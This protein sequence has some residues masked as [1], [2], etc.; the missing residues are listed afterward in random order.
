MAD[1]Q[2]QTPAAQ[3][4]AGQAQVGERRLTASEV[5]EDLAEDMKQADRLPFELIPVQLEKATDVPRPRV[6][7]TLIRLVDEARQDARAQLDF[8]RLR[9]G[10]RRQRG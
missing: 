3:T 1:V 5:G 10:R 9:L 4:P 7:I 6:A 2:V 8:A